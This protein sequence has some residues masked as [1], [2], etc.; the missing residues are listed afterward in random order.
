MLVLV[1]SLLGAFSEDA[2]G[3]VGV[4]WQP[5]L[6]CSNSISAVQSLSRY[7]SVFLSQSIQ[8]VVVV[9]V[10]TARI[11]AAW[12]PCCVLLVASGG[13]V[14]CP[15]GLGFMSPLKCRF[16]WKIKATWLPRETIPQSHTYTAHI[17]KFIHRVKWR[18][19]VYGHD[20]IA[21]LWV[22]HDIL[23]WV[24]WRRFIVLLK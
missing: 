22:Q 6:C 2:D 15:R 11:A 17:P 14:H 19:R 5:P 21:I 4:R 3:F 23:R 9:V 10:A 1:M 16:R 13:R 20:T 18:H 24:K 8:Q 7:L 12:R